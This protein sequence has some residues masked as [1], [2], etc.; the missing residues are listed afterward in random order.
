MISDS[1]STGPSTGTGP[2]GS[3]DFTVYLH[4]SCGG[5]AVREERPIG[6]FHLGQS[7]KEK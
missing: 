2:P 6:P 5:A 4:A 3:A 7:E 1:P